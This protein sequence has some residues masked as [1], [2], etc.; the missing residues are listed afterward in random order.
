[1]GFASESH[2]AA[3]RYLL[4]RGLIPR[5]DWGRVHFKAHVVVSR[6]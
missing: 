6:I 3:I 2:K 1:M 4:G 5:P